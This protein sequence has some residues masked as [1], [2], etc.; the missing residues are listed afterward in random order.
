MTQ[1]NQEAHVARN[2]IADCAKTREMDEQPLLELRRQ[3]VSEVCTLG[4]PPHPLSD[5]GGFSREAE[6]IRK[7][8]KPFCDTLLQFRSSSV[9]HR[10]SNFAHVKNSPS[11]YTAISNRNEGVFHVDTF[12]SRHL[13]TQ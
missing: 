1:S 7:Y 8:A 2:A 10:S 6:K 5:L 9:Q 12:L 3:R 11:N 4:E 13:W